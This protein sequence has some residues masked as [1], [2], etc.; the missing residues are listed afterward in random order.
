[1]VDRIEK[2]KPA[3]YWKIQAAADP[4]KDKRGKSD[5]EKQ[6]D[7]HQDQ[8]SSFE[9]KPDWNRLIAKDSGKR[10]TLNIHRGDIQSLLF[11]GVSTARDMASLEVDIVMSDGS[12]QDSALIA[13]SRA[14]GLKLVHYK[15]GDPISLN[16]FGQDPYLKA[17]VVLH[18]RILQEANAAGQ[19]AAP[20]EP[21]T[22]AVLPQEVKTR[23]DEVQKALSAKQIVLYTICVILIFLVA[24]GVT[25]LL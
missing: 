7:Q 3:E 17:S 23:A 1:M 5:E 2:L 22:Q 25:R 21:L 8:H 16:V 19:R 15:P 10:E 9:E 14:E 11:K 24:Y 13:V 20:E 6:Q 4:K 18:Q 12:R